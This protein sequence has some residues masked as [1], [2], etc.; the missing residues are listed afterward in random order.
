MIVRYDHDQGCS[1]SVV[2]R[3]QVVN[4]LGNLDEPICRIADMPIANHALLVNNHESWKGM[5]IV[6][7]RHAFGF[8][9]RII[10]AQLI[11]PIKKSNTTTLPR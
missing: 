6:F 2:A 3:Q 7:F 11:D 5:D 9:C 8:E 4:G 1:G 10:E